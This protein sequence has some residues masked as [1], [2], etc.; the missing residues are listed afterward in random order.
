MWG[1]SIAPRVKRKTVA[2]IPPVAEIVV[3]PRGSVSRYAL[4]NP[5]VWSDAW[6]ASVLPVSLVIPVP[7]LWTGFR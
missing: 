6:R 4:K 2:A 5:L 1:S 7:W 3:F